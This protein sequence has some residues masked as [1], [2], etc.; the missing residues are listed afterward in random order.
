M[1]GDRRSLTDRICDAARTQ[2][3]IVVAVGP[4]TTVADIQ[5]RAGHMACL[6]AV[7]NPDGSWT[8]VR[9]EPAD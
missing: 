7:D 5:T 3:P 1:P 4:D 9:W 8:F 2:L 6:L